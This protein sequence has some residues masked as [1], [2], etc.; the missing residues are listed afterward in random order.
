MKYQLKSTWKN[1][2]PPGLVGVTVGVVWYWSGI[3]IGL[4]FSKAP[5]KYTN[6]G[7][8]VFFVVWYWPGIGIGG[9]GLGFLDHHKVTQKGAR[10]CNVWCGL[11]LVWYRYWTW[12]FGS[13]NKLHKR[14]LVCVFLLWSGFGLVS[15]LSLSFR[16]HQKVTQTGTR[17][18]NLFGGLV[19]VWY[20]SWVWVLEA[21]KS[22]THGGSFV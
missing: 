9:I 14:G 10:L 1:T 2:W 5:N 20:R 13:T 7:S 3:G 8:V 18:C 19:L 17:L 12:I 16:K 4:G 21:P 15:V 22:Y 6:G 11:V